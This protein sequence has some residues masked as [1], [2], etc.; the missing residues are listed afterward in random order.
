MNSADENY[1]LVVQEKN[2]VEER[3]P[4]EHSRTQHETDQTDNSSRN[5]RVDGDTSQ[6]ETSSNGSDA[7]DV[8]NRNSLN[9][10]VSLHRVAAESFSANKENGPETVFMTGVREPDSAALDGVD[11]MSPLDPEDY[12]C[13]ASQTTI[14][15]RDHEVIAKHPDHNVEKTELSDADSSEP[16]LV[17]LVIS[18]DNAPDVSNTQV[19]ED[20][21]DSYVEVKLS[22][23]QISDAIGSR[24][25]LEK[26]MVPRV[27][28]WERRK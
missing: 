9:E 26:A 11:Q 6:K 17:H 14:T 1:S 12:E 5:D 7:S 3:A 8:S 28:R 2:E 21:N 19:I 10:E 27:G 24:M 22:I 18:E 4:E 13:K 25:E 16:P 23:A 15:G 20:A